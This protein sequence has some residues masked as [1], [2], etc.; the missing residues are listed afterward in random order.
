MS[1]SAL[2]SYKSTKGH[3]DKVG[4]SPEDFQALVESSYEHVCDLRQKV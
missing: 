1:E 4:V 2:N 3:A